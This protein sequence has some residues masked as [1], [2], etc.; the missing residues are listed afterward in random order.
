MGWFIKTNLVPCLKKTCSI[1]DIKDLALRQLEN[2]VDPNIVASEFF[3]SM[4][5]IDP[6]F[7]SSAMQGM[8]NNAELLRNYISQITDPGTSSMTPPAMEGQPQLPSA[9]TPTGEPET[10]ESEV[11]PQSMAPSDAVETIVMDESASGFDSDINNIKQL[12]QPKDFNP[13]LMPSRKRRS[14]DGDETEDTTIPT[15]PEVPGAEPTVPGAEP[16]VGGEEEEEDD[17]PI[18]IKPT[19]PSR[20]PLLNYSFDIP[21][22]K[23]KSFVT[24]FARVQKFARDHKQAIPDYSPKLTLGQ[25]EKSLPTFKKPYTDKNG[26]KAY[27]DMIT[28]KIF[29]TLPVPS[30]LASRKLRDKDGKFILDANGQKVEKSF[31]Y[32]MVA[33]IEWLN[34]PNDPAKEVEFPTLKEADRKSVV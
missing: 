2:H 22:R 32:R 7:D 31:F 27:L 8:A 30:G 1:S 13:L 18:D 10:D 4:S 6:T 23:Y 14:K 29:G 19:G 11:P 17:E 34:L 25:A 26:V 20:D 28:V 9:T 12:E 5:A 3:N 16:E 21:A 24:Q 33:E 15:E